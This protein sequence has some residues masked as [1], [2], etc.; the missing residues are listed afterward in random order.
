[1][2]LSAATAALE[3]LPKK[4]SFGVG[5]VGSCEEFVSLGQVTGGSVEGSG[6]T[7]DTFRSRRVYK[8]HKAAVLIYPP[9]ALPPYMG[10]S[11]SL[12]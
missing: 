10:Q 12:Q 4:P 6:Y 7:R 5:Q 8:V 2:P 1:M 11:Y 3:K 9:V